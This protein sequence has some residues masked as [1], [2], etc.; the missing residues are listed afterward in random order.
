[1]TNSKQTREKKNQILLMRKKCFHKFGCG[2]SFAIKFVI[3]ELSWYQFRCRTNTV[4]S[5]ITIGF[6][7]FLSAISLKYF[8]CWR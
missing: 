4:V 8:Y 5:F 6:K 2:V 3:Q 1:M 7:Q